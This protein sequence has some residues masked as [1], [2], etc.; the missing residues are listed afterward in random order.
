MTMLPK[1]E[2]LEK[3][4]QIHEQVEL[5]LAELPKGLAKDRLRLVV[6]LAKYLKNAVELGD[7]A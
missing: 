1:N 2:L 6:G 5:T 4:T 7:D 3:L